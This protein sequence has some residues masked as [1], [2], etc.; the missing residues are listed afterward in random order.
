MPAWLQEFMPIL[1]L[2]AV[3]AF[4]IARLPKVEEVTH[5]VQVDPNTGVRTDSTTLS[6]SYGFFG[7]TR[8]PT[9]T[10][11]LALPPDTILGTA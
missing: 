3:V 5:S 1:I 7:L 11:M 8:P 10:P 9:P 4:V 6:Y 2:L